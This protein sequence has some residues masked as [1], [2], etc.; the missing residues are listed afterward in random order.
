MS[1]L[2]M[3]M[4]LSQSL[5][6]RLGRLWQKLKQDKKVRYSATALLA[7]AIG[8]ALVYFLHNH[9]VGSIR[10]N[11]YVSK[12]MAPTGLVLNTWALTGRWWPTRAQAWSWF[13]YWLP[14]SA[15]NTAYTIWL[16]TTFDVGGVWVRGIVAL[17]FFLVDYAAKRW[18]IFGKYGELARF[19]LTKVWLWLYCGALVK[20]DTA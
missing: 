8:Y 20:T 11:E 3:S 13:V 5:R 16:V 9:G 1:A 18:I 4:P 2:P 15:R 19:Y 10:A 12:G 14:S 6:D 17:T 7:D